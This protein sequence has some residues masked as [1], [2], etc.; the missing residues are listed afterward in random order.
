M[1]LV[2]AL[3]RRCSSSRESV[4]SEGTPHYR[5][6][7]SD[8]DP[9]VIEHYDD[10]DSIVS[11]EY[12]LPENYDRTE[13]DYLG[14]ILLNLFKDQTQLAQKCNMKGMCT[15]INEFCD[16]F[17]GYLQ[18][19]E[20]QRKL[21]NEQSQSEMEHRLIQKQLNSHLLNQAIRPP[22]YFSSTPI[23]NSSI[24]RTADIHKLFPNTH[25]KFSGLAKDNLSLLEFLNSMNAAQAQ[26]KL[27]ENEFK[28]MLLAC[29]T[30]E[31][32]QFLVDWLDS[33][34]EDVASTYH[35]L[36]LRFDVRTSPEE[37]KVELFNYKAPKD[38]TLA[39][40]ESHIMNLSYRAN[41]IFPAGEART[42]AHNL[43]TCNTLIRCLPPVSS[44]TVRKEYADL[45]TKLGRICTATE[46]SRGLHTAR[47]AINKDIQMHGADPQRAYRARNISKGKSGRFHANYGLDIYTSPI[48]A[49]SSYSTQAVRPQ[50]T[51]GAKQTSSGRRGNTHRNIPHRHFA[52]RG[53]HVRGA[54]KRGH[55]RRPN[56]KKSCSLCGQY[57]HCLPNTCPNM[58]NDNGNLVRL[59]PIQGTCPQCPGMK[60]NSLHHP[61]ALCPF[62]PLGPLHKK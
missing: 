5:R 62:R 34:Q 6:A 55:D 37:A 48:R 14:K 23:M 45:S 19:N 1:E 7:H 24:A 11:E 40:V 53:G 60:K 25:H 28:D 8:P 17:N 47:H 20:E 30:G 44:A 3:K 15:N 51:R 29:T 58:R 12:A 4:K 59:H 27:S 49:N 13:K 39:Q 54:S 46:L 57:S 41:S 38:K 50:P 52:S 9:P 43:D 21:Q 31:A 32:H 56:N 35:Q 42:T 61:S 16:Y 18:I 36:S 26:A 22:A 2:Q 33:S 10:N